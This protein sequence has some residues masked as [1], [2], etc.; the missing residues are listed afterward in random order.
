MPKIQIHS[1]RNYG[2]AKF[3]DFTMDG[4]PYVAVPK[5]GS[6]QG[7]LI[8]FK[9]LLEFSAKYNLNPFATPIKADPV[10]SEKY[11]GMRSYDRVRYSWNKDDTIQG[12]AHPGLKDYMDVVPKDKIDTYLEQRRPPEAVQ[13]KMV[14]SNL[15]EILQKKG[16]PKTAERLQRAT[17]NL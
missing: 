2:G 5:M 7:W 4:K 11:K 14:L 8:E 15:V 13:T 6:D 3:L 1:E 10:K 12:K 17:S 9:K 16:L